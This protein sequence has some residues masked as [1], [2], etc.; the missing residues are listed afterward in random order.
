MSIFKLSGIQKFY[1]FS[2]Y[3]TIK[4]TIVDTTKREEKNIIK[5]SY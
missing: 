2:G 3:L 1:K 4:D 5:N